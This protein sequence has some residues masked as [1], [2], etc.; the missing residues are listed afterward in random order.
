M[1][2]VKSY[3]QKL[4]E[5]QA[6]SQKEQKKP[7]LVLFLLSYPIPSTQSEKKKISLFQ[8]DKIKNEAFKYACLFYVRTAQMLVIKMHQKKLG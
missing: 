6:V 5:Y 2:Q 8:K 7:W 4:S 3:V 1:K